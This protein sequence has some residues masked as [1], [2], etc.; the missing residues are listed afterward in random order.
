MH[1]IL[2]LVIILLIS[3]HSGYL[4]CQEIV[5]SDIISVYDKPLEF[6]GWHGPVSS[7][8]ELDAIKIGLFAPDEP[9]HPL[10]SSITDAANLAIEEANRN[11]GY[12][13]IPFSIITRWSD[14]PWG[15]GSKEMVKLVYED[16]VWAVIGSLDG[17]SSH[18]AEQIV[19]KAWLPLISS[20]SSDPTL[21]YIRIP[22]MFRLPPDDEAQAKII[23]KQGI[24]TNDL[25]RL[26]IITSANHDG[27]IFA[28]EMINI[29]ENN[30]CPPI[31]HFHVPVRAAQFKDLARK[32]LKFNPDGI[33]LD[34]P[35]TE[36]Y[37]L[38]SEFHSLRCHFYIMMPWI[39][40]LMRTKCLK[41]YWGKIYTIQPF[42]RSS[43]PIR[44]KFEDKYY[45]KYER[46]PT[47]AA[48]YTY[49]AVKLIINSLKKS[50]LNRSKLR[51]ELSKLEN[52][53]G[54]TGKILW[55][56]CGGN[57]GKPVLKLISEH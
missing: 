23:Y 3:P 13:G 33:I 19:T 47:P 44:S 22:W 5:Q 37:S 38:L 9:S 2:V 49:D 30:H 12:S 24:Q 56:N 21:N 43:N 31:F 14:D 8:L 41:I 27:H 54:V 50:G 4:R 35:A 53:Q 1:V 6:T 7:G 45:K 36:V 42:L 20:I 11:G 18:I 17:E 52:F 34:L 39:P 46:K 25:Y 40:G 10:G 28:D 57:T 55:D 29:L 32:V 16:K 48:A 26:G 51:D 15:S